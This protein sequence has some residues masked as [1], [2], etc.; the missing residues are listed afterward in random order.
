MEVKMYGIVNQAIE[1]LVTENYGKEAWDKIL[2]T[3]GVNIRNFISNESYD[4][5]VTYQLAGAAS[6]VLEITLEQVLEAFGRYWVLNT[7]LKKYGNMMK[8]GGSNFEEFMHNLP[9]FHTRVALIYPALQPPEFTVEGDGKGR[10]FLNYYSGREG[11]SHFVIGLMYGLG[12][13]YGETVAV[14]QIAFKANGDNN[15]KFLVTW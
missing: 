14:Q 12:D 5:D 1:G 8:S 10:M 9:N 3:S 15:D 2:E 13:L 7:G 6:K 4:D 11:L